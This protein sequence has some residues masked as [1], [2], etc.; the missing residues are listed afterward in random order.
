MRW[1]VT[2]KANDKQ[3]FVNLDDLKDEYGHDQLGYA[4]CLPN[5]AKLDGSYYNMPNILPSSGLGFT[6]SIISNENGVFDTPIEIVF[7][8]AR[9]KTSDGVRFVFNRLSNDYCN[10]LHLDWKKN[11]EVVY[12][13]DYQPD[14]YDYTC[15]GDVGS[16]DELVAI[17]KGTNKPN[18]YL[19]ISLFDNY[20]LSQSEGLKIIYKDLAVSNSSSIK[21]SAND[22]TSFSHLEKLKDEAT[23]T[24]GVGFL[25][26]RYSKLDGN[27]KNTSNINNEGFAYVSNEISDSKGAF[28]ETKHPSLTFD[29]DEKIS[30]IGITLTFNTFTGDYCD[31]L[32]I[33]WY[34]DGEMISTKDFNPD[35][36]AYFC[37]NRVDYYNKIII[38]FKHTSKPY[39][40]IFVSSVLLGVNRIYYEKDIVDCN[41]FMD[42]SPISE[43]L[44]INTL[45][46]NVRKKDDYPFD[47]QKRQLIQLFFDKQ[48]FGN[49]YLKS[50]AK[51]NKNE[52]SIVSEDAISILDTNDFVGGIYDGT[53]VTQ[54]IADIFNKEEISYYVDDELSNKKIYGYIPYCTKREAL[55]LVCFS[56]GAIVNTSFDDRVFIYPLRTEKER[57]ISLSEI[58]SQPSLSVEH[59]DVVTGINL[60]VHSYSKVIDDNLKQELFNEVLNGETML[61]FD[62]PQ[63][64][65]EIVGGTISNSGPNFCVIKGTGAQVKLTGYSYN[66]QTQVI[67]MENKDVTR[68]KKYVDVEDVTTVTSSNASD[69]LNR[70]YS[71]YSNSEKVTATIL[72]GENEVGSVIDIDTEFDGIKSGI[73][74]SADLS[75]TSEVKGAIEVKCL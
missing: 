27:F 19:F 11:N 50:G 49:F 13:A 64:T 73:I 63:H 9:P 30:S 45:E 68:N 74:K 52:H 69:I 40:N 16:W 10:D 4:F 25:L 17:F 33:E 29:F 21:P 75:F 15:Q 59:E 66:H 51:K 7:K 57:N 65:F 46:F 20:A 62:G 12:S 47:F 34:K 24:P 41:C 3:P 36:K 26:P 32:T 39:R 48:I 1:E 38:K 44:S 5:Y 28:K 60:T 23:L 67:T 35:D 37:F 42:I 43:E 14:N 61:T 22:C 6:S 18:R 8:F 2:V 72:M 53:L 31:H 55:A 71:Y 58:Y 56:I 70:L 54:V